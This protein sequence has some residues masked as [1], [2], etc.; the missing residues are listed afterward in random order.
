MD[1]NTGSSAVL[2]PL[3]QRNGRAHKVA[4]KVSAQVAL[5]QKDVMAL[6]WLSHPQITLWQNKV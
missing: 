5:H 3:D 2:L 1:N 4:D 6:K